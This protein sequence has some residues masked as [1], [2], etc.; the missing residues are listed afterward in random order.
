MTWQDLVANYSWLIVGVVVALAVGV[1]V[2]A[3]RKNTD[4]ADS[5]DDH[6]RYRKP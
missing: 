6:W 5:S 2:R 4:A 3:A 1:Y